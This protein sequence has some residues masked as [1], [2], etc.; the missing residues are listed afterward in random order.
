MSGMR[1]GKGRQFLGR[2]LSQMS[3]AG[4]RRSWAE[5]I[6]L[7]PD[8]A[9]AVQSEAGIL[10]WVTSVALVRA[11]AG[12]KLSGTSAITNCWKRSPGAAWASSIERGR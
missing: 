2:P 6:Q 4:R 7:L 10:H 8:A 9:A 1:D 12:H 3:F 5:R 11:A